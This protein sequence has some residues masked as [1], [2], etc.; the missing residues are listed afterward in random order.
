MNNSKW[1]PIL[2][3]ILL[4]VWVNSS[5]LV[6]NEQVKT[7]LSKTST[8]S[9]YGKSNVTDAELLD[10]AV[11]TRLYCGNYPSEPVKKSSNCLTL[12]CSGQPQK[13]TGYDRRGF[14]IQSLI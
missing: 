3:T 8:L 10:T 7:F 6:L 11:S 1:L 9:I 4:N 2:L 12:R 5:E 13:F 14:I